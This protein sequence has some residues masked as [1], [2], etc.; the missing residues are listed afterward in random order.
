MANRR[1]LISVSDK[2]GLL[3]VARALLDAGYE[4]V[5]SDGTAATLRDSGLATKTIE[6]ITGSPEILD[7]RVKSLHPAIH[8]AILFDREDPQQIK[9]AEANGLT[10]IDIVIVNLYPA[11]KF[12]IGGPA[13]IRAA[14]KNHRAVSVI[15]APEQYPELI[16]SLA[17]GSDPVQRKNWAAVAIDRT[18]RYDLAILADFSRPLRYGENPHQ[19]GKVFGSAGLASGELIQGSELSF[20]NYL[21]GDS[22]TR[23]ANEFD[24]PTAV[25]VKHG[26]PVGVA[27]NA[28]PAKAVIGALSGDPLSAFGG[29][30][31]TNFEISGEV[32]QELE[33]KFLELL[34]APAIS[35]EARLILAKRTK[36]RIFCVKRI[37]DQ[38]EFRMINGGLLFQNSDQLKGSNDQPE[39]WRLVSGPAVDA[40]KLAD[41]HFAWKIA[42]RCRSNS[43]VIAHD[44]VALGI[45]AGQVNRLAAAELAIA[46]AG[47]RSIGSVA[48]SDGFFPFA[49]GITS[50]IKA[51][52]IAVVSPGGSI[53]DEEVI[54]AAT[55]ANLSLYFTGIRHF[56]HN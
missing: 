53:R 54:A 22:A 51:G 21:D 38:F 23:L 55:A 2:T 42:A 40:G 26:I 14:A 27:I 36:L 8:G 31:A 48:A 50:L 25:I 20:N 34:I 39:N 5:A 11:D 28:H 33:E 52:V 12:D 7:G 10:A 15:T 41:L 17:K 24:E 13:L 18:T 19:N 4:I 3:E 43:I 45:G 49:D 9:E 29:V 16:E 1:A 35:K 46:R 56:S 32:A 47:D 6:E 30:L 44:Q 37:E